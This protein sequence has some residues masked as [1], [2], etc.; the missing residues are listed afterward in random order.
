MMTHVL[1]ILGLIAAVIVWHLIQRHA[2]GPD[3]ATACG[4]PRKNSDCENR[5]DEID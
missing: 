3:G 5:W 1:A 2:F 4:R